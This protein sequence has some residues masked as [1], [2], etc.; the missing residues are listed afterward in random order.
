M[1]ASSFCSSSSHSASNPP[2]TSDVCGPDMVVE[3]IRT[4]PHYLRPTVRSNLGMTTTTRDGNRSQQKIDPVTVPCVCGLSS[5]TLAAA[6]E[7]IGVM[8][9]F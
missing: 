2:A 3:E 1:L 7:G 4:A 6:K 5:E 8:D 9:R